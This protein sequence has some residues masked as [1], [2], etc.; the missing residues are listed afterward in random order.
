MSFYIQVINDEIHVVIPL[1]EQFDTTELIEVPSLPS[2]DIQQAWV[3]REIEGS[4]SI[5]VDQDKLLQLQ[6][7]QMPQLTPIEFDLKLNAHGLYQA[8]QEMVAN[9]LTLKIAYT[10]ATFFKRTD[11]FIDQARQLLGLSDEQV[12]ALWIDALQTQ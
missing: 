6:R 12:D 7:E 8:V 11:P 4:F 10:R 3:L 5:E 2:L 1:N 9:N